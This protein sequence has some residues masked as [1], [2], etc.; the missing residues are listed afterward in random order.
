[1]ENAVW[2]DP[3]PKGS[4]EVE[5]HYFGPCGEVAETHVT[6]SVAV[7]GSV[8]G[9]YRYTLQPEERVQAVSFEVR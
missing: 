4:Y 2:P 9:V 6:V 7:H 5:L 1:M 8:A 3:T